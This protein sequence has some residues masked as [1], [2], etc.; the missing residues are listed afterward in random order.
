MT[1]KRLVFSILFLVGAALALFS[2]I[3]FT[4]GIA[5]MVV[6]YSE[7]R[8]TSL[9]DFTSL[10]DWVKDVVWEEIESYFGKDKAENGQSEK[11]SRGHS[12]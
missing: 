9:V 7:F 1:T 6:G 8:N 11:V 2:N 3:K 10:K 12:K 4:I 5:L